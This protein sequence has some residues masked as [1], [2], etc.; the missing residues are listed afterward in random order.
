MSTSRPVIFH[1]DFISP[2]SYLASQLLAR[3]PFDAISIDCRPV[4]FGSMLSKLDVK[5]PGEI[6]ARRR[7]GLQDVLLLADR[8]RIP[9]EGPPTHPFNSIYALRSVCAVESS[10]QRRRLTDRYFRA[11]W[12]ESKDLADPQVL[13]QLALEVGVD[14][15]PEA[16]ASDR[17]IRQQLKKQTQAL[18]E[19][20]GW[21]VPSFVVGEVLLF[22]H[23]RIDM[24]RALAAGEVEPN[25]TKLQALLDRP[26]PGRVI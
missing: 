13:R 15:D 16:V 12:A 7:A 14:H 11:G 23:E 20:G 5:G 25:T 22:G 19:L 17:S 26:Q 21:G 18:L 9:L 4:V 8:Y 10:E 3:S 1:F 24:A 6:P 2:Y